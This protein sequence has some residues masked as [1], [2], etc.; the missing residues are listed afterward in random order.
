[1]GKFAAPSAFSVVD[2]KRPKV[3]NK[4]MGN[5]SDNQPANIATFGMCSSLMNPQ[6]ASAT[7]SAYGV[8]T[9]QPCTPKIAGTWAPGGKE[10]VSKKPALL[11][12]CKCMCSYGGTIS[13]SMPGNIC[14]AEGK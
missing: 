14:A 11:D 9:P 5:I 12:N 6:V 8:L 10:T 3:Q 13:I 4:L 2:M 7:A 1:M